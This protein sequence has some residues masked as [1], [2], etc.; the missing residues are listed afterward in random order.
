VRARAAFAAVIALF[1]TRAQGAPA[2]MAPISDRVREHDG[3]AL[4]SASSASRIASAFS[5]FQR[6]ILGGG[7]G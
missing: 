4:V 7:G 2:L 3:D 1:A 6:F 5:R